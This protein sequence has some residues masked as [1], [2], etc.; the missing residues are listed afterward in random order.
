[1]DEAWRKRHNLKGF[2]EKN[3]QERDGWMAY[4]ATYEAVP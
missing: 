3:R 2:F 4:S 1:M